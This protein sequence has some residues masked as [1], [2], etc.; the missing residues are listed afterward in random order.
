MILNLQGV[1]NPFIINRVQLNPYSD[2]KIRLIS[3]NVLLSERPSIGIYKLTTNMI[4]RELGSTSRILA[5]F[6]IDERKRLITFVPRKKNWFKLRTKDFF[7][8]DIKLS[9]LTSDTE[10]FFE[11]FACQFKI[12]ETYGGFQ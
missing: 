10:L 3:L 7:S 4:E 8:A 12:Q 11:E 9:S 1:N 6:V 2:Y 5:F